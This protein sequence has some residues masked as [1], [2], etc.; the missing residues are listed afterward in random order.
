MSIVSLKKIR[1]YGCSSEKQQILDDLQ[2]MGCL[3]IIPLHT[4]EN[5]LEK[6][7]PSSRVREALKHLQSCPQRLKQIK[8]P[9]A[10]D[11]VAIEEKVLKN[12]HQM[13]SLQDERDSLQGKIKELAP[14][15]NFVMPAPEEIGNQRLWFY[16]IPH[17][18]VKNIKKDRVCL[19]QINKDNRF[20]YVVAVSESEPESMPGTQIRLGRESMDALKNRLDQVEFE[21]EDVQ[22]ERIKLT[23]W[24]E[25]FEKNFS[26]LEDRAELQHVAE[27]T[28]DDKPVFALQA[29]VISK[30]VDQV[31]KY[32]KDK[33][34]AFDI[35]DPQPN[36]A[37]PT[38]LDNSPL[39][40]SGQ[41][42]VSF[43]KMPNYWLWDP[44]ATVLFSFTV[45][46]AMILSDAGYA[47]ML[48]GLL[49]FFWKRMGKSDG[50]RRFR[51]LLG[52]LTCAALVW[53]V[54]VG[55]YFGVA[56]PE[57]SFLGSL[58]LFDI[59]DY[60]FM[61]RLAVAIGI[62]HIIIANLAQAWC[63]K[64]SLLAIASLGWVIALVGA[65]LL[66][67]ASM[68]PEASKTLQSTGYWLIGS[69]LAAV[70]LFSS[71]EKSIVKRLAGGFLGLTRVLTLFGDVLSY[72]RLFALGLASAS[73]ALVFN[74]MARQIY[75]EKPGIGV[76]FA[77]LIL[78]FGHVLNF[79]L[80]MM[81][82]FIHGLRL[83]FIEFF[84]WSLPDEG[85]SFRAFAKKESLTG[86]R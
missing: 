56:P 4:E 64:R 47:L 5:I 52:L 28:Y 75:P 12:K 42:L 24:L 51:T 60:T 38:L 63:Q 25:L 30:D 31:K 54:L 76:L 8:E 34:L 62:I 35:N 58:K 85:Y 19:Q 1:M 9:A 80:S 43:Y 39:M 65:S 78:L 44:S 32:A 81:S 23:R 14:W 50:G 77:L 67:A 84:N 46:F 17:N 79:T 86:N 66:A 41:D 59:N 13:E 61:M 48:G 6:G 36:E 57:G 37:L 68:F 15:G 11:P 53:G 69:G 2:T 70:L 40:K 72:L 3:H 16:V 29:W 45:F 71:V 83:N 33:C 7:G 49:L 82:G 20:L 73:L 55:S 74:D 26:K 27:E 10:F 21:L 18:D 22:E